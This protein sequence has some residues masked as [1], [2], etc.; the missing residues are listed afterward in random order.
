MLF[1]FGWIFPLLWIIGACCCMYSRNPYEA[2]WGK[3]NLIMTVLL[4]TTSIGYT[5]TAL[6]IGNWSLY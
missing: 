6:Y 5:F 3:V 4:F 1:L 2:W